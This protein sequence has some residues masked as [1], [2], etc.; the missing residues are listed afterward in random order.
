M[1]FFYYE[2]AI[3]FWVP[4]AEF[5]SLNMEC[6]PQAC[7]LC[8]WT[9]SGVGAILG[10]MTNFKSWGP[11]VGNRSIWEDPLVYLVS[12]ALLSLSTCLLPICLEVESF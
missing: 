11:A 3:S 9:P 4:G 10:V 6:P 2:I 5:C 1:N 7:V 8:V 12:C